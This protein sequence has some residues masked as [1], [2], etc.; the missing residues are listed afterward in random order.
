MKHKHNQTHNIFN[1]SILILALISLLLLTNAS[2]FLIG[3]DGSSS[4]FNGTIDEFVIYNRTLTL[5][6]IEKLYNKGLNNNGSCDIFYIEPEYS[7]FSPYPE[8]T[9]FSTETD[10]TSVTN[11][12]IAA[13]HG[14]IQFPA[15]YG[16]NADTQKYDDN[17]IIGDCFVSVNTSALDSTFNATAFL[18]FN[19]SDGHCGDNLI[20]ET[21]GFPSSAGEIRQGNKKCILCSNLQKTNNFVTRFNVAHFSA[22]AIGSNT[23]LDIYDEYEGSYAP[24]NTNIT[25]YANYTNYTSGDH[26]GGADCIIEFDDNPGTTYA[27]TDNGANYN[28]TKSGGFSTEALHSWNVTCSNATGG[29]NTLNA[30]DDVQVGA[31]AAIPEFSILT[32]G[33]GLIAVLAGLIII[34]RRI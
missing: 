26:I 14:K 18:T 15:E 5:S 17:V 31:L 19:N 10:L 4:F 23:R 2:A 25:F 29:W 33:L 27:M 30:T 13:E 3:G 20:Y 32:L 1:K 24:A 16:V 22:Y 6:E 11:M 7:Q 12:I 34:R 8:T 28:Y 21:E 9:D